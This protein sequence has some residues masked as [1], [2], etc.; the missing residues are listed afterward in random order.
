MQ[1]KFYLVGGAIRDKLLGK[2]CKDFDYTVEAPSFDA[3]R[4]AIIARGG[5]IFVEQEQY[6]TIRAKVPKLGAA[7]Y[8]LARRD[9]SYAIDGRRPD[10]VEIG[11]L[12]DDLAR[13]DF[14]VNAMAE[15][16]DGTLIDLF[17]GQADLQKKILRCVGNTEKR[18]KEDSLRMLRALR[19][20]LTK[21]FALDSELRDFLLRQ[22]SADLLENISIERVREELLKCFEFDTLETLRMLEGFWRIRNHIFSR[23]IKLTPTIF[24]KKV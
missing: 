21:G 6:L 23:N 7:D 22:D 5:E 2:P 18:M 4:A 1:A 9:G 16:E 24:V 14:T 12:A 10:F 15:A 17:G 20:S 19:F 11:T 3:M 8:V 13:R